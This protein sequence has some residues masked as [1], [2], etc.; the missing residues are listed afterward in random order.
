MTMMNVTSVTTT[1]TDITENN[2]EPEEKPIVKVL[3]KGYVR[4]VEVMGSD[5]SVVN[6]ARASYA[7]ES[8]EFDEKDDRLL[9]FLIREGHTSP[10]RHAF[11]TFEFKAPLMVA[12]QHWKYVVGSDHTMDAWNEASRRYI[13]MTPEFY[14]PDHHQWRDKPENSKQGSGGAVARLKGI[15]YTNVLRDLLKKSLNAYNQ[16]LEDGIAPEQARLFLPAY[17]MYTI[18]RWSASLASVIHFLNQRVAEDAQWEIQQYAQ[19]VLLLTQPHFP[20][21]LKG[22]MT[23]DVLA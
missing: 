17:G 6:A 13:T 7:K 18:Y 9:Q 14:V 23:E 4:L 11:M 1:T 16:A 22:L 3:D 10:F 8:L 21:S 19:A 15:H 5:L 2:D 20:A 12:R